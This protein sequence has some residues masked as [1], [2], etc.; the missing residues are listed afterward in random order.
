MTPSSTLAATAFKTDSNGVITE[1]RP[2][3]TGTIV[4][5]QFGSSAT[6]EAVLL[7]TNTSVNTAN[8]TSTGTSTGD[9]TS[10]SPT[11]LT[12]GGGGGGG[13]CFIATAAYGSYL[14]P[15]V[16][17]LRDFRDRVLLANASGRALVRLYYRL[18][19]PLADSVRGHESLRVAA[20]LLLTPIVYGVKHPLDVL[21]GFLALGASGLI[22]LRQ[23]RIAATSPS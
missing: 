14:A 1:Y 13:G 12:F 10:T 17:V 4:I 15:E 21:F 8:S 11:N 18:S 19:P 9:S 16:T 6:A 3:T 20:R 23:R 7:V 5:R 22:L 2:D